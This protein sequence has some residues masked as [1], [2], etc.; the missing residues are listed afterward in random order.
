M[1]VVTNSIKPLDLEN[2]LDPRL[3][4]M[5]YSQDKLK[6]GIFKGCEN[7]NW[8]TQNANSY[9]TSGTVW[10]FNTQ[11]ENVLIDRRIYVKHQ[12]KMSFTG[13]S[14]IG[15]PLLNDEFD[16]PRA[17]PLASVT[18]S[19]KVTINGTSVEMQYA[20]ALQ[21]MLRYN[22]DFELMNY[23]LSGTPNTLDNY[24]NYADGAGSVRN[25]LSNYFNGSY[26][27]GRGSFQLDAPFTNPVSV[28]GVTPT[29]STV[30]FTVVEPLLV[31]PMLYSCKD[32]QS[33]LLGVKNM[34]V[35][36]NFK[37]GQL[38]KIWSHGVNP[39]V[40][41]TSTLVEIGAG[42]TETP[43]LLIN[44]LNPPLIDI[45]LQ[46]KDIVY[47]YYKT[48][49]YVND[50]NDS[51]APNATKTYSNNSIQLSTVPKRIYIYASIPHSE[52]SY[53][54][55]DTFFKINS[56]SLQYLNVSGQFST[57]TIYDLY[58]LCVKNGLKM[59]WVDFNGVTQRYSTGTQVGLCGA[60]LCIDVEDLAI[61]SNL[62]SG[63]N[64]N[65]Q[66]SFQ[67]N[68]TNINQTT[69]L[70]VQLTTV[71]VY[72]GMATI[73][74]G[75]MITQVGVIN[76][77]DVVNTRQ[78]GKWIDYKSARS[79]Y[80]GDFFSK[81]ASLGQTALSGAKSACNLAKTAGLGLAGEMVWGN[82]LVG[83]AKAKRYPKGTRK[84][85]KKK[86]GE[87]EDDEGGEYE[88]GRMLSR[89]ELRSRLM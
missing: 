40:T 47:Q 68:I 70:N 81:L 21:A 9:S 5:K 87:L 55:T 20:D 82:A 13:T 33:G 65:S 67:L 73:A 60:V 63:V 57:M 52:Q 50:M 25:C 54:T 18:N 51:L 17:F 43:Q 22:A 71:L 6:W 10:N 42:V 32:L 59:N 8:V 19:L 46:P 49:T 1:S 12:F 16:A 58:H 11:S 30:L 79:V 77:Y 85:C 39:G 69:E 23:D 2:V 38:S 26:T 74:D 45:G 80:G 29:T 41:I 24:Q 4:A 75:G 7:Q 15:Q 78:A 31:S 35:S 83:G 27:L 72:D 56:L 64:V 66:L 89:S 53:L 76:Q 3:N 88:G 34:G 37:A 14:P 44:Y 62:A 36:F 28:D 48:D 61:P 84:V 86:G